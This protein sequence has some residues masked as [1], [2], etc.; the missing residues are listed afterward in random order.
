MAKS[1]PKFGEIGATGLPVYGGL[2]YDEPVTALSGG[3]WTKAV[4]SMTANDPTIRAVL[5]TIEM[6]VR[7]VKWDVEPFSEDTK[8]LENAL[9]V[10]E[11][12]M[13]DMNGTW[14]E[15]VAEILSMVPWGWSWME[16]CYKR[17][18]GIKQNP[19]ESSKFSD[20]KVGWSKWAIRA[21]ESLDEWVFDDFGNVTALKQRPAPDFRLRQIPKAKSLHF[22]TSSQKNNPEGYAILR[23]IYRPWFFKNNIENIEGIGIERDLAGIPIIEAPVQIFK[24]DATPAEKD[25]LQYL[26][27]LA[28][29]TYRNEKEGI[30]FPQDF[31]GKG[32]PLYKISL[33]TSGG[34]RQFDTSGIIDR[35]DQRILMSVMADFLLLGSKSVG[36]YALSTDKT[37]LFLSAITA[38]LDSIC[39]T[40][41]RFAIPQ[42]MNLNGLDMRR[43]P[44]LTHGTVEKLSLKELGD[45]ISQLHSAGVVFDPEEQAYLKRQ[46]NIPVTKQ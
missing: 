41:N 8:D 14:Q 15:T 9:F 2:I 10:L 20:G 17:R 29:E 27:Q 35:Y 36:S 43:S 19:D 26:T 1:A 34:R 23:S 46:G 45:Y 18:N 37:E 16:M 7:Q 25:L 24:S 3:N 38:W 13:D 28:T 22:R 44:K 40:I 31:D 11:C 30:V 33:L 42:L 4:R 21:Q 5:M 6:M 39:E 12:L 32:N